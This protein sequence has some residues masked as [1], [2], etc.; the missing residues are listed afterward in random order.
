MSSWKSKN[1]DRGP[2]E[3]EKLGRVRSEVWEAWKRWQGWVQDSPGCGLWA[4][5]FRA[6]SEE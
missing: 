5:C 2:H 3:A 4:L 1:L 6:R